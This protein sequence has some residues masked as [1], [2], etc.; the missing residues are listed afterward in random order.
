MEQ[1]QLEIG[2][3]TCGHCVAAVRRALGK[4]EGVAVQDV[5]IGSATVAYD[6]ARVQPEAIAEV[7]RDEG[8]D[9]EPLAR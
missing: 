8:Y 9:A 3:M 6:P 1:L 2:G 4:V 5:A 7:I